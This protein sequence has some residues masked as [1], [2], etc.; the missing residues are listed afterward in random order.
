VVAVAIIAAAL[1]PPPGRARGVERV[2][3]FQV[4]AGPLTIALALLVPLAVVAV[5]TAAGGD[6]HARTVRS[7]PALPQT[8]LQSTHGH[9]RARGGAGDAA[10]L[11]AGVAIGA[12][13]LT[14]VL[15]AGRRGRAPGLPASPRTAVA[16]GVRDAREAIAIPADPRAAVLA[17]YARMEA[18][19][20][21]AGLA[22]RAS[23]APREYL[24]RITGR[25]HVAAEPTERL[26]AL[27][28]RA[29]FSPHDVDDAMRR[30]AVNALD[31]IAADLRDDPA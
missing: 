29:R 14:V 31:R 20:A 9:E 22:R 5:L 16:D 25:L 3:T 19:L 4:R 18:A 30:A 17:A 2:P 23:E 15:L 21:R 26:T 28:E 13:G 7:L 24:A 11:A 1:W 12:L 10:G 27:F 8:R 6:R